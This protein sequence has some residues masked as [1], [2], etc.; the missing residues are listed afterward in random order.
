MWMIMDINQPGRR[1]GTTV[2]VVAAW[3]VRCSPWYVSLSEMT[4]SARIQSSRSKL[5]KQD[6]GYQASKAPANRL[7][8]GGPAG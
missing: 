2:R 3:V 8:R 7:I 5:C 1:Y 6:A 4:L